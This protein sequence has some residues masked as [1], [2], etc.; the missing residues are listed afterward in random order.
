[1][2]CV[3]CYVLTK[4]K[5]PFGDTLHRQANILSG[6]Y[7]LSS[8]EDD[9]LSMLLIRYMIAFDPLNRPTASAILENPFFWSKSKILS[10][11]QDVSDRIEK[12][13]AENFVVQN[14]EKNGSYV[15]RKDWRFCIDS[16]VAK[17]LRKFRNYHGDRVRELLRALRN[18][19]HHY[20]ELSEKAQKNLGEIPEDFVSYWTKRFPLLLIH[21]WIAMQCV[22][23]EPVF[24]IYY[25][26]DYDFPNLTEEDYIKYEFDWEGF[27]D[28]DDKE[29]FMLESTDLLEKGKAEGSNGK[30]K[31]LEECI[32]EL[33]SSSLD[34]K[35]VWFQ[36]WLKSDFKDEEAFVN[37]R[38]CE[39]N[40]KK[41]GK[42]CSD[43]FN[44]PESVTWQLREKFRSLVLESQQV[45]NAHSPK[46]SKPKK[47]YQKKFNNKKSE[48][49]KPVSTLNS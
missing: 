30:I 2:G 12:E 25:D 22:K 38:E 35:N 23:T 49:K 8:L 39:S 9:H 19:K 21:A 3:F 45:F 15:V 27:L 46:K 11:F 31:P 33:K 36:K 40:S 48:A 28:D 7:D 1:M 41:T 43:K 16:E 10:F 5:H 17:D 24:S 13:D 29:L 18:K 47:Y 37:W 42:D 14:L 32:S 20:R 26:S 44:V 6:N 34:F 4:G